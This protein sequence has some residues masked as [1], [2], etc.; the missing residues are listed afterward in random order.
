VKPS[1]PDPEEC[2]RVLERHGVPDH[3][4]RHSEQVARVARQLSEALCGEGVELD[5][6]LVE[7]S[8]LLHD[9]S[10]A[11]CLEGG[12]HARQGAELLTTL[13]YPEVAA[14]VARHVELGSWEPNGQVT[15]AEVL[16]YSDKRVRHE[17]VVS[18]RER[19]EDLVVRYGRR[20]A[21]AEHRI[22]MNWQTTEHL[23]AKI[24]RGL[25]FGPEA[26]RGE[27][28]GTGGG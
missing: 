16:N 6:G 23:E 10:K 19:F 3:I 22:R 7:A 27:K 5:V 11:E 1:V 12:D 13:G 24:F 26:V 8:A 18:L 2:A 9:I 17:D 15:E 4:R 28:G 20:G 25:P 14:L 21:G